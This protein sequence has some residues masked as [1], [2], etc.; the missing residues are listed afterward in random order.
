MP[1]VDREMIRE[2]LT[3]GDAEDLSA[4]EMDYTSHAGSLRRKEDVP[5]AEHVHGHDLFGAAGRV[6]SNRPEVNDGVAAGRRSLDGS[7]IEQVT[8]ISD[9]EAHYCMALPL[10]ALGH[11]DAH[12]A[13]VPGD[14]DAHE[15]EHRA[16]Q[17]AG[18]RSAP[19]V[20]RG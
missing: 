6:V 10:E 12:T 16:L 2:P 11:R 9:V 20:R 15:Y 13:T 3:V 4:R 19:P 18:T 7:Q 17:V 14:E 8:T 1:V 5:G